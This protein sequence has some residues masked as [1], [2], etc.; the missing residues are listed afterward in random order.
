ML[1]MGMIFTGNIHADMK[2][3]PEQQ[4]WVMIKI[5]TLFNVSSMLELVDDVTELVELKQLGELDGHSSGA[6]QFEFNY[7]NVENYEVT[8]R[9][10]EAYLKEKY[11]DIVFT[12]SDEY[13][14]PYESSNK[15]MDN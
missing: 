14:V 4:L 15:K 9:V 5:D 13:E 1:C 6:Y 7:Y 3:A 11:S 2:E 10:I 8:K 12:I